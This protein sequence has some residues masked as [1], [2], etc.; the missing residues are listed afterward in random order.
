MQPS[1]EGHNLS[2]SWMD[3]SKMVGRSTDTLTCQA[4]THTRSSHARAFGPRELLANVKDELVTGREGACTRDNCEQW[5][6]VTS[7]SVLWQNVA[8]TLE[9]LEHGKASALKQ[10]LLEG[11]PARI[12][13][14]VAR[15]SDLEN[16]AYMS[17]PAPD[18]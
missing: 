7:E 12:F 10:V 11:C 17:G 3:N 1:R 8:G 2:V 6:E 4:L 18:R 15:R 16:R 5:E 14:R 13:E 9:M